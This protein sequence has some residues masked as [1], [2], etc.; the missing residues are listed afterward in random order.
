V[1]PLFLWQGH[2]AAAIKIPS[3]YPEKA[4]RLVVKAFFVR[5]EQGNPEKWLKEVILHLTYTEI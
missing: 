4:G 2:F 5:L 1:T 3:P